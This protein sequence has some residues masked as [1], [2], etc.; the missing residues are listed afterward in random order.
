LDRIH[1]PSST[2]STVKSSSPEEAASYDDSLT[3]PALSSRRGFLNCVMLVDMADTTDEAQE[4]DG[5]GDHNDWLID[6]AG[7]ETF[8]A[9]DPSSTW[10]GPDRAEPS[11]EEAGA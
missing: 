7:E 10:S 5:A 4:A 6:E 3:T 8:P 9:S 2:A 11:V 1:V